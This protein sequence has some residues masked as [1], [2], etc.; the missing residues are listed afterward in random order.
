MFSRA[1]VRVIVLGV[2]A[3]AASFFGFGISYLIGW[4]LPLFVFI[5]ISFG[6]GAAAI[7]VSYIEHKENRAYKK[8]ISR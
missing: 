7:G 2:I 1:T 4:S 6:V 5:T 8:F 3:I